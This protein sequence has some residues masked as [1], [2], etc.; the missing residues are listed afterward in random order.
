MSPLAC[1]PP[2]PGARPARRRTLISLTPLIDVVFILLVF[3]MLASSFLD[4]RSIALSTP[5]E[6][7]AGVAVEGAL[8]VEVGADGRLRLSGETL[9]EA[10]LVARLAARVVARPGRRVLLRAERGVALQRTVALL[11]RIAGAGI[12]DV[13]LVRGRGP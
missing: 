13:A 5:V 2:R 12:A 1:V 3:F 4:W 9:D 6:T 8:L 10:A 11:D 7:R